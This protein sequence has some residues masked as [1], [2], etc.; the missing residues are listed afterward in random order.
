[1]KDKT[2][3]QPMDDSTREV[4]T[5]APITRTQRPCGAIKQLVKEMHALFPETP[6]EYS[7]FDPYNRALDVTF[8]LT[9]L[10]ADTDKTN[11]TNL[12]LLL[13][14]PAHNVERRIEDVIVASDMDSVLVSMR[15]SLRT[16]DNPEP[17]GLA[18]ALHILSGD[19]GYDDDDDDLGVFGDPMS[20]PGLGYRF[21]PFGGSQ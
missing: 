8:D 16:Q 5:A 2:E 12:L 11:A 19:E 20:H 10:D 4:A 13:A 18:D 14:D 3:P 6:V 7:N 21:D 15:A 9:P 1:M 17:F